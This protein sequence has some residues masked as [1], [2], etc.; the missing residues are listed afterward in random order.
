MVVRL[1]YSVLGTS[2]TNEIT[3]ALVK[4]RK[5]LELHVEETQGYT[6]RERELALSR[7]SIPHISFTLSPAGELQ[8][9][10]VAPPNRNW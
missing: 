5:K 2:L 6:T 8:A 1:P 9:A 4:S 7:L 10:I 3:S